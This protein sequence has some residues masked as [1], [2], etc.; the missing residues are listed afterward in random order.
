MKITKAEIVISAVS[1]KQ[2]PTEGI[3]E[4]ALA[5]RSNVGKSSFINKMINRKNLARTSSKPGKTQTLNFYKLNDAFYFVDV[6]GYGYAKISKKE[7]EK[8]GGMMEEYFQTRETLKAVLLVTDIRHEPTKDDIQMYAYLKHFQ[9]PVVVV[10]TKMDKIPKG[11]RMK[12]VNRTIQALNMQQE[13]AI[14]PFS[15]ETGE[16]K[17]LAWETLRSYLN[18]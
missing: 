3:P 9:L 4:I 2:Y 17:D 8:W 5:G 18:H 6:P 13:D 1:Q 11:K 12:H 7:R 15:A 10:A 14:I 16:G